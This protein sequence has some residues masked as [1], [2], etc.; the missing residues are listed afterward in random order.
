MNDITI[1]PDKPLGYGYDDETLI[2]IIEDNGFVKIGNLLITEYDDFYETF[3]FKK[4]NESIKEISSLENEGKLF[5]FNCIENDDIIISNV[6]N[7][8]KYEINPMIKWIN[9]DIEE[10]DSL[11]KEILELE[12]NREDV[13]YFKEMKAVCYRDKENNDLKNNRVFKRLMDENP[14]RLVHNFDALIKEIIKA[15]E[16]ELKEG[17]FYIP[18][19]ASDVVIEL[20]EDD[21]VFWIQEKWR[22]IKKGEISINEWIDEGITQIGSRNIRNQIKK[23]KRQGYKYIQPLISQSSEDF[24]KE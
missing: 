1:T 3:I 18:I 19:D 14:N 13:A 7:L 24:F 2:K 9:I 17:G 10:A 15:K 6:K 20:M 5:Y 8:P 22:I 16:V 11:E 23:F 21:D 12:K 4:C